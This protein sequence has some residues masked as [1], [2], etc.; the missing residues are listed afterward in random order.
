[1]NSNESLVGFSEKQNANGILM[2][3]LVPALLIG[4]FELLPFA[5]DL[6]SRLPDGAHSYSLL[7]NLLLT[8]LP[9]FV[10]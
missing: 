4:S 1:M 2:R 10:F 8:G 7:A 3:N 6:S 5:A 9:F